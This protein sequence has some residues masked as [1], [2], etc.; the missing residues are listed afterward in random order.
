VK[1]RVAVLTV[2]VTLLA[3]VPTVALGDSAH[4]ASNSQTFN[5]SIGEDVNAPDITNVVVSNDDA[6][7]ITFQVNI[8][9]RPALTAD[10]LLLID[11]DTDRNSA[12]GDPQA[13]GTDYAIQLVPG[14][15]ELFKWNGSDYALAPSQASL[16]YAY[17][18]TG[19]T[20]KIS[21][22]DLG[23]SA[24]FNFDVLAV[25][26][27]AT[28]AA[29]NPDFTNAHVDRAPDTGHGMFAYQV[30]TKLVLSVTAFSTA[31]KPPRAGRP[32]S[33]S[34]AANENDTAGPVQKGTVSCGATIAGRR[35]VAVSRRLTNGVAAC[36]WRIPK[37]AKAK[38]IRGTIALTV[39]GVVVSR[40]FVL[41][42]G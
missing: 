39:Q 32:F 10:M 36:V 12:T 4:S 18:S 42:I 23:K 24:G 22:A 37:T 5:D 38:T 2:L 40:S 17:Q 33:A 1:T 27:I 29:G 31:P 9:N 8:S 19:A 34:L 25:S 28:D 16:V 15:V 30:K 14:S 7:L 13:F 26:G 35:I 41:R 6:G 20:I 3:L 21:A 11:L